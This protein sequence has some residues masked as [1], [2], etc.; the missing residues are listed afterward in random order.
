MNR[1]TTKRYG[2][3]FILI[4]GLSVFQALNQPA[5]V[6]RWLKLVEYILFAFYVSKHLD[7]KKDFPTV[8]KLLSIGVLFES[9]LVIAQWFKQGS[10]F[11]YWFFGENVR[12]QLVLS[13]DY[14]FFIHD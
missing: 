2:V 14:L 10:I 7:L 1:H 4:S 13:V 12:H 3:F 6:Y 9:V 11:G 5:A 8:V